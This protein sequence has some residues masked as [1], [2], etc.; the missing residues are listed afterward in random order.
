M[1]VHAEIMLNKLQKHNLQ[2]TVS[3]CSDADKSASFLGIAC[4]ADKPMQFRILNA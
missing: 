1:Q 4:R 3:G 2:Q